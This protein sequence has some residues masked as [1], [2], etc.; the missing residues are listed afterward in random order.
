MVKTIALPEDVYEELSALKK[1]SGAETY[2][3][4]VKM[5]IDVYRRFRVQALKEVIGRLKLPEE[6][7]VKVERAVSEV[8][9]RRWWS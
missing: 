9:G 6:E 5:L 2:G 3:E 7:A 8:K 1:E 4:L